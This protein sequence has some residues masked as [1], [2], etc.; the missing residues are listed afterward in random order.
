MEVN[1]EAILILKNIFYPKENIFKKVIIED[2]EYKLDEIDEKPITIK[3]NEYES[4][5]CS[6]IVKIIFKYEGQDDEEQIFEVIPGITNGILFPNHGGVV[7]DIIFMEEQ[8]YKVKIQFGLDKKELEFRNNRLLLINFSLQYTLKINDILL[9]NQILG[10]SEIYSTQICVIDLA[11]RILFRK[12]IIYE[13]FNLFFELYENN[14]N[15]ASDFFNEIQN[16]F[17]VQKFDHSEFLKLFDK[18]YLGDVLCIKYNLP[19][20]ILYDKY[21]KKEYF[22]FISICCLYYILFYVK[23]ENNEEKLKGIFNYFIKFKTELEKD[24]NLENYMK[25]IIIMEFALIFEEKKDLEK[26][27]N[28]KFKYYNLNLI[29]KESPLNI[30]LEF[31]KNFIENLEEKSP[32]FY[33]LS[34]IDSGN[35]IYNTNNVYGLG[36]TNIDILKTHLRNIFPDIIIIVDDEEI[37]LEEAKANK[38][39]GSVILNFASKFLSPLKQFD[40]DKKIENEDINN[41]IALIIFITLFH[42]ILGHIKGGFSIRNNELLLSPNAYYD[43]KKNAILKF[44]DRNTPYVAKNEINILREEDTDTDAGYFLEYF[45]GE[46]EY[47]FFSELIEIMIS[48]NVNLNFILDNELWGKNIE[49]LRKYI[50]LKYILFCYDKNLLNKKKYKDINEEIIDLEDIILSKNIKLNEIKGEEKNNSPDTKTMKRK[51]QELS[52]HRNHEAKKLDKYKK[53]S[54][55]EIKEKLDSKDTPQELRKILFKVLLQRVRRK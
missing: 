9:T 45:I 34:L 32:F 3:F 11:K 5:L 55:Y 52:Y 43:K 29:E 47:G 51:K 6:K 17:R 23:E 36:L 19:K 21:N 31:L 49:I 53:L 54:Y 13:N 24:L 35:Y 20:K 7:R 30:A 42:E 14:K 40:I 4:E 46:C 37:N 18:G 25:N 38:V 50:R 2:Q 26:F 16:F 41:N 1:K 48:G 8:N 27:K 33:P 28:L 15:S 22:D 12:N 44:V 39:L 10:S